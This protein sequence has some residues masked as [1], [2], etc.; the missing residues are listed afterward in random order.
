MVAHKYLMVFF[1]LISSTAFAQPSLVGSWKSDSGKV[2]V[3]NSKN[4][5]INV[6]AKVEGQRIMFDTGTLE[7]LSKKDSK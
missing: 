3:I 7:I 1:L 2:M 5:R 4:G 6:W